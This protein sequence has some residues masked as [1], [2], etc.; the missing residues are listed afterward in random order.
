MDVWIFI[1][2]SARR[3]RKAVAL[4]AS[5][6]EGG[7][8][9]LASPPVPFG[10]A[11]VGRVPI[12]LLRKTAFAGTARRRLEERVTAAGRYPKTLGYVLGRVRRA[13]PRLVRVCVSGEVQADVLG[14]LSPW[15][16]L[17]CWRAFLLRS[18]LRPTTYRRCLSPHPAR[19]PPGQARCFPSREGAALP[20]K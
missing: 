1:S 20:R 11:Y 12:A 5:G 6:C 10:G 9:P 18:G 4:A 19:P 17:G 13:E 7:R 14:V 15:V 3:R 8:A 2:G 16:F